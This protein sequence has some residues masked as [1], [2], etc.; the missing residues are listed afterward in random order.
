MTLLLLCPSQVP[1][2]FVTAMA[3]V[4][5]FAQA[6]PKQYGGLE[7]NSTYLTRMADITGKL[8]L[9][10]LLWL[11]LLSSGIIRSSHSQTIWRTQFHVSHKNITILRVSRLIV[12]CLGEVLRE[13]L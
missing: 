10:M 8:L 3:D 2:E 13:N 4:G 11:L 9:L 7:L 6:I 5:L 12:W 1:L